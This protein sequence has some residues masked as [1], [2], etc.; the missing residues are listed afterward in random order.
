MTKGVLAG[1]RRTL[2]DFLAT[3]NLAPYIRYVYPVPHMI[4][5]LDYFFS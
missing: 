4:C 5:R 2:T 3:Q 1:I